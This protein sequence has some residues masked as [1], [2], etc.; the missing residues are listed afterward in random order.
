MDH[1][2]V[3]L[4]R[5]G[6]WEHLQEVRSQEDRQADQQSEAECQQAVELEFLN[7]SLALTPMANN[8]LISDGGEHVEALANDGNEDEFETS[9]VRREVVLVAGPADLD[10]LVILIHD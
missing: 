4:F 7:L 9:K 1:L 3:Q 2:L 8:V 5:S 10:D 6:P